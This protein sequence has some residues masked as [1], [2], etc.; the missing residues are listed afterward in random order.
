MAVV[1]FALTP[2]KIGAI[3]QNLTPLCHGARTWAN[4]SPFALTSGFESEN[5]TL[6]NM[7]LYLRYIVIF[8]LSIQETELELT[9]SLIPKPEIHF[10]KQFETYL[11]TV[12]DLNE[13]AWNSFQ[14]QMPRHLVHET[15]L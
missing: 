5:E 2:Q 13:A 11:N 15:R 6:L 14:W 8:K 4:V 1:R 9:N 7:L 10:Q 12:R 3:N